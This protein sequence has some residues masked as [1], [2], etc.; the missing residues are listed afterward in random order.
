MAMI[1][2]RNP[3]LRERFAKIAV[4]YMRHGESLGIRWD[5]AM[6]QMIVE[7]NALKFTGDVKWRQNNFAGL[8][9]IGNG[10]RGESF[11]SVSDGAKAHLQHLMI[12]ADIHVDD[13]VADRTR[14]VQEWGVL[15]KWHRRVRKPITFSQIGSQWAPG[16]RGYARDIQGVAKIFK[17]KYCNAPDPHPEM[18][19]E[20]RGTNL[21][22]TTVAT[23]QRPLPHDQRSGLGVGVPAKPQVSAAP[24][25][26][27]Q[28]RRTDTTTPSTKF[29][30]LNS[31]AG[32]QPPVAEK[33]A[34]V[35]V[36]SAA[37][38]AARFA[39]P[40]L[41]PQQFDPVPPPAQKPDTAPA[42]T[43]TARPPAAKPKPDKIQKTPEPDKCRVW[44]A[45]Y[46]G[47]RSIIIRSIAQGS[48]NFTVLDVNDERAT[49]EAAAYIAAYAKGGEK[50]GE[51]KNQ[52]LAL[53]HAFK[54]CP[55]G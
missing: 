24:P 16:D 35:T 2:D 20:A 30:V 12:Y 36:A 50:I 8:G 18:V 51:F 43:V 46:G 13:P 52:T 3:A 9:A 31:T 19:A 41:R 49:R 7:T 26:T 28:P 42:T 38:A 1:R 5:Y 15:D 14:K 33:P 21:T 34:N 29:T 32:A 44:T 25:A 27:S 45:S 47:E 39:S 11:A 23:T 48:V 10:A 37:G 4:E 55:S 6:Y 22:P 53:E 17:R 40:F 54:L